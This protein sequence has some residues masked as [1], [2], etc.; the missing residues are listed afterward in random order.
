M[1]SASTAR[2]CDTVL[3]I[4]MRIVALSDLHGFLPDIHER[5]LSRGWIDGPRPGR[6]SAV[7]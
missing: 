7:I 1:L 2:R 4:L 5:V 6:S 3:A